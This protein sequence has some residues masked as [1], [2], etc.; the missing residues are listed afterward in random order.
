HLRGAGRRRTQINYTAATNGTTAWTLGASGAQSNWY[1]LT[2]I[3]LNTDESHTST[4]LSL[5]DLG[6]PTIDDCFIT[7]TDIGVRIAGRNM[8]KVTNSAFAGARPL[9]FAQNPTLPN[10]FEDCDICAFDNV[11]LLAGTT[12]PVLTFEHGVQISEWT[13][14]NS[15]WGL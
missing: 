9:V 11:Q 5:I 12:S 2:G 1:T 7:A 10:S 8:Y 6:E 14:K 3:S 4:A 13:Y 15:F